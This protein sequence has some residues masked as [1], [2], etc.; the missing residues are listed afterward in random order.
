MAGRGE[1]TGG[2]WG[3]CVLTMCSVVRMMQYGLADL[4][5]ER[6]TAKISMSNEPSIT[7][8][9]KLGFE[10]CAG[11]AMVPSKR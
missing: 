11:M 7:L 2:S 10:V 1:P 5:V 4:K 3:C 9:K 6:Y 8:F